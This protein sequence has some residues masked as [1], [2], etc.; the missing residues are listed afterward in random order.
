MRRPQ[1]QIASGGN[2]SGSKPTGGVRSSGFE[3]AG[4][5][6]GPNV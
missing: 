3:L 1:S 6:G 5:Y 4:T 2:E